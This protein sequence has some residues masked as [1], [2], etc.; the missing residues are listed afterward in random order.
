MSSINSASLCGEQLVRERRATGRVTRVPAL[1]ESVVEGE[2]LYNRGI[3]LG[4]LFKFLKRQF[5]ILIE[6]HEGKNFVH[7]LFGCIFILRQLDHLSCHF[8]DTTHD[9]QHLIVRD[10]AIVIDVVQLE[11]PAEFFI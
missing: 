4:P 7:A 9:S 1:N 3:L 11:R 5:G 2:G 10:R 6:V 8:V